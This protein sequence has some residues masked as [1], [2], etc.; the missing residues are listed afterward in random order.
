MKVVFEMREKEKG[1]I[2]MEYMILTAFILV[3][4]AII[5]AFSFVNYNQNMRTAKTAE[6]LAKLANAVDDD[7]VGQR[8]AD[9]VTD[10][11]DRRDRSGSRARRATAVARPRRTRSR[12]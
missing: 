1:Q 9:H 12:G 4:V 7:L 2:A 8:R 10:R 5:F 6:A 11:G 3:S